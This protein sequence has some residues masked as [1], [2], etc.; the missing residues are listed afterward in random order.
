M[1]VCVCFIC[2][3]WL[4]CRP[5]TDIG[6]CRLWDHNHQLGISIF[7]VD[8]ALTQLVRSILPVL[9][10][11]CCFFFSSGLLPG[12]LVSGDTNILIH[13][14]IHPY[15]YTYMQWLDMFSCVSSKY[16]TMFQVGYNV[17]LKWPTMSEKSINICSLWI[18]CC[19][20]KISTDLLLNLVISSIANAN[21]LL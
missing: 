17:I 14:Y 16:P 12:Q 15:I 18:F 2:I 6:V 7:L 8:L 4:P 19:L 21:L 9:T 3:R 20:I 10:F 5:L 13:A 1:Y 11:M